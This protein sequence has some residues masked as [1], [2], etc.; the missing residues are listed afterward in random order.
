MDVGH[1][2]VDFVCELLGPVVAQICRCYWDVDAFGCEVGFHACDERAKLGDG[3][4]F[5]EEDFV[6]DDEAYEGVCAV[7][8]EDLV[9]LLEL[10]GIGGSVCILPDAHP[11]LDFPFKAELVDGMDYQFG[12]V[13]VGTIEPNGVSQ[14]GENCHISS[15]VVLRSWVGEAVGVLCIHWG[16]VDSREDLV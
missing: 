13:A 1:Y 2:V 14:L 10:A 15:D 5:A 16:V 11:Y 3:H 7:G 9:H 8:I 12:L 6:A 4:V